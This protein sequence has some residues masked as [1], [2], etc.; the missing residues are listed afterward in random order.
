MAEVFSSHLVPPAAAV[1]EDSVLAA[2]TEPGPVLRRIS[3]KCQPDRKRDC[4]RGFSGEGVS[5][6]PSLL[7]FFN[8]AK[9]TNDV[10]FLKIY[11][12]VVYKMFVMDG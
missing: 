7:L 2:G 12:H 1:A 10:F 3:A 8:T 4:G 11:R 9:M 5:S 6:T